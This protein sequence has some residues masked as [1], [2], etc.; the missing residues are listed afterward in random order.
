[1]PWAIFLKVK[2]PNSISKEKS[3]TIFKARSC[4]ICHNLHKD[5]LNRMMLFRTR[6]ILLHGEFEIYNTK[7]PV[8]SCI[9]HKYIESTTVCFGL[10]NYD[11]Q[12]GGPRLARRYLLSWVR[13]SIL[14]TFPN[15]SNAF[16]HRSKT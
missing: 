16:F 2:G 9:N 4:K 11:R 5:M 8:T 15:S 10:I 6:K 13:I 7:T 12:R 14:C 3:A 1:M